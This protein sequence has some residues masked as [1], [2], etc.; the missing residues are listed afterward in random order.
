MIYSASIIHKVFKEVLDFFFSCPWHLKYH[1][2][3]LIHLLKVTDTLMLS[4]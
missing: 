2:L 3:I 4:I 1:V